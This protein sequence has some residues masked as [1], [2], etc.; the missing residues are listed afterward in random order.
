MPDTLA[1]VCGK[2]RAL[3]NDLDVQE[4]RDSVLLPYVGMAQSE[5]DGFLASKGIERYRLEATVSV[6]AGTT[7]LSATSSPPL[8]GDLK[9]PI[10]LHERP[11][12][13]TNVSDWRGMVQIR[14][15][16]PN[17]EPGETLGLWGWQGGAIRFLGATTNREV[18]IDY[19][20][21]PPEV[22]LPTDVLPMIDS[23]EALAYLT[24][25]KVCLSK[26]ADQAYA[27]FTREYARAR[28]ALYGAAM[29]Q[30]QRRVLRRQQQTRGRFARS[31][32]I[33]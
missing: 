29:R 23:A 28:E 31:P 2:V 6:P 25:A 10:V 18:Q 17:R 32:Y 15:D 20:T 21:V 12:G 11:A 4:Y 14:E 33:T 22:A 9:Q 8:P 5:L 26:G 30:R 16:L 7:V 24:A 3:L 1:T 19:L 27:M 13:S